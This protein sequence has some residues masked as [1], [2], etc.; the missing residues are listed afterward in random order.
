MEDPTWELVDVALWSA[1]EL[2]TGVI[3]VSLPSLR[4][5]FLQLKSL[6]RRRDEFRQSFDTSQ[7][8]QS[9]STVESAMPLKEMR[10]SSTESTL[11][12]TKSPSVQA[13]TPHSPVSSFWQEIRSYPSKNTQNQ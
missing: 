2:V 11:K 13:P 7:N 6:Y 3:C 4:A 8:P 5:I 1:L 9:D 10:L 12:L